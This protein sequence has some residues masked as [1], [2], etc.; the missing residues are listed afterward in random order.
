MAFRR[1]GIDQIVFCKKGTLLAVLPA[2]PTNVIAGGLRGK[3]KLTIK[4][5][6]NNDESRGRFM[7]IG[8]LFTLDETPLYQPSLL[9]LMNIISQYLPDGGADAEIK[10]RPQSSG[11]D[12]GCFQFSGAGTT[13]QHLGIGFKYEL[14]KKRRALL[15]KGMLQLNPTLAAALVNAA[16]SNTPVTFSGVTNYG[17]DET[18]R[19]FPW[20]NFTNSIFGYNEILD[21]SLILESVK[22]SEN[23]LNERE[24]SQMVKATLTYKFN[25]ATIANLVSRMAEAEGLAINFQEDTSAASATY[26]KFVFNQ[27]VLHKEATAEL[28]DDVG[29]DTLVY[30][31]LIPIGNISA[32]YTALVGGGTSAD[33]TEGGTITFSN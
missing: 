22:D 17:I 21:Y 4:D 9:N 2:T 19:R 13:N 16:D 1:V 29:N 15:I 18:K 8:K 11:V 12:G 31:G 3:T 10:M 5:V 20:I 26:E 33:G 30:S 7:E 23:D 32:A 25:S 28:G 24:I 27:Y 6:G 14:S